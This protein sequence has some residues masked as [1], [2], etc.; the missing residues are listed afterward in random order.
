MKKKAVLISIVAIVALAAATAVSQTLDAFNPNA[1]LPVY[2]AHKLPDGKILICGN[3]TKI[4][5]VTTGYLAR[6]NSD[7]TRDAT[8]VSPNPSGI[9]NQII[10]LP[11]GKFVITGGFDL[12]GGLTRRRVARLNADFTVDATFD[13][14]ITSGNGVGRGALMPDGKIVL[15]I[16][17]AISWGVYRLNTNGSID[18]TFVEPEL[19]SIASKV[20]YDAASNKMY[21]IGGFTTV[22]GSTRRGIMRLNLDGSVDTAFQPPT[23]SGTGTFYDM[24]PLPDG[25]IYV[26]GTVQGLGGETGRNYIARL[27]SNASLDTTFASVAFGPGTNP[28]IYAAEIL[29]SGKLLIAGAF[30]TVNGQNRMNMARLNADGTL[31]PTFRDMIVGTTASSFNGPAFLDPLG[32]GKYFVG[33]S[34]VSVDGQTR[35]RIARITLAD[36]VAAGPTDLD[37]DG[38]GKAD[39]GVFRSS[40]RNWY[41]RRSSNGT[42]ATQNWGLTTDVLTPADYDGD[43]KTDIAVWR[44]EP[45]DP[46]KA[47]FYILK[48]SDSTVSI[49]QFG[50]TGDDPS[51][52]GDFNGDGKA[53]LAVFRPGTGGGQSYFFYRSVSSPPDSWVTT[54]WGV[55]GDVPLVG[56]YDGDGRTDIAVF[57]PSNG[58]WYILE[59]GTSSV[60]YAQ[61]GLA[62]D[63]F[64][65]ADYDGDGKTDLAVFRNGV[66]YILNSNGGSVRYGYLGIATDLP[67]PADY[68]GDGKADLGVYRDGTWWLDQSTSGLAAQ[69]FGLPTD[70]PLPNLRV[71]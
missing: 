44:D 58:F 29:P 11:D 10:P 63:S 68:D 28:G 4:G 65:P 46:N 25:K 12:V 1:D 32:D 64:V 14:G 15:G 71:D 13:A 19:N 38:D 22:N 2:Q 62:S 33:G 37:F 59:S 16:S 6:L 35:N 54:P 20:V 43:G 23:I 27:N 57:R 8:F 47:N 60:R 30:P 69:P 52:S 55:D 3:V 49:Q 9:V 40:D 34:F 42:V 56:D 50:R 21:V 45:S 66:W 51:I 26:A 70:L 48:S 18:N 31:D 39:L 5:N 7:G 67:V 61:W 41:I 24:V 36:E 17:S 53:D